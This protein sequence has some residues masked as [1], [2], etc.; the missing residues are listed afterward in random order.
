MHRPTF[1]NHHNPALVHEEP[2]NRLPAQSQPLRQFLNSI[3][4][5]N[6]TLL[7]RLW[8][9]GRRVRRFC[10]ARVTRLGVPASLQS[11]GS[12]SAFTDTLK[13]FIGFWPC[14]WNELSS[15]S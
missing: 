11:V 15:A 4:F 9:S 7:T 12:F 5:F 6:H 1:P 8:L 2:V 14:F 13:T 10:S 3:M